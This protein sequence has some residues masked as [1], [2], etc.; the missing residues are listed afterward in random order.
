VKAPQVFKGYWNNPDETAAQFKGGW[1]MTGDLIKKDRNGYIYL[2]G[3]VRDM[4]RTGGVNVYPAE[5]EPVLRAHPKVKDA[6]IVGVPHPDWGEM[7][8]ACVIAQ[9]D[10][11]EDEIRAHCRDKL[12]PYKRPKQVVFVDS[13]PENQIGKVV[14]RELRDMLMKVKSS[15]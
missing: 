15:S 2:S 12:A 7:V 1:F 9:K 10:T 14:K 13:F 6:A 8:V 3:R 4:V 11:S 5:I